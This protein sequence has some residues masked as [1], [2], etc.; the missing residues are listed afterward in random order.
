MGIHVDPRTGAA[1]VWLAEPMDWPD[2]PALAGLST[3]DITAWYLLYADD[4]NTDEQARIDVA[5]D[6]LRRL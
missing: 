3:A 5:A 6:L 2:P 4:A 1:S